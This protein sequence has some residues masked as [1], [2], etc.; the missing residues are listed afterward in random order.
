VRGLPVTEPGTA[1][2]ARRAAGQGLAGLAAESSPG[3]PFPS[4]VCDCLFDDG[5][6]DPF[7]LQA[8]GQ[9]VGVRLEVGVEG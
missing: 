5:E 8:D 4:A 7:L 2:D 3:L 6:A 1:A 9:G